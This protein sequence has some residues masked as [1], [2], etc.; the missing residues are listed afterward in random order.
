MGRT[1]WQ[2]MGW[3][4][5]WLSQL[6][7]QQLS[8]PEGRQQILG[9]LKELKKIYDLFNNNGKEVPKGRIGKLSS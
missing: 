2:T 9:N 8:N 4:V 3:L 1:Q 6:T 7:P 5:N